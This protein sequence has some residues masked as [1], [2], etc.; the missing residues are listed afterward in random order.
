MLPKQIQAGET[1]SS[2]STEFIQTLYRVID[3]HFDKFSVSM[4]IY[5]PHILFHGQAQ[6]VLVLL[7]EKTSQSQQVCDRFRELGEQ[8]CNIIG[9][10][11][12]GYV[13]KNNDYSK[14]W[15]DEMPQFRDHSLFFDCRAG[16]GGDQW[17]APWLE[18]KMK[19]EL[20]PQMHQ[21]LEEWTDHHPMPQMHQSLEEW[22][23]HHPAPGTETSAAGSDARDR[24]APATVPG[25]LQARVYVS[26]EEMRE[27]ILPC[28][29]CLKLGKANP[30]GFKRDECMLSIFA[31]SKDTNTK[32][33]LLCFGCKEKVKVK[34]ILKRPLFLSYNWG[35]DL[36]TQKI[37]VPLC[38]R[39]FLATEMPYWLDVDGGM[40][41]GDEL[42]TEMREG[43]AGCDIVILMISDA[44]CNSGNCLREF[45]HTVNHRKHII[46]LLV[47]DC[48]PVRENGPSSGWTGEY[49]TGDE[50]WWKHAASICTSKDPDAPDKA[51]QWSYLSAFT[52]IDL[53]NESLNEDG[54]LQ[55]HSDAEKEI[56]LR[57]MSRF[58]RSSVQSGSS[59][60]AT[61]Q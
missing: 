17:N 51:I 35:K 30:G 41:F 52:P 26:K 1:E 23:D 29:N 7:D 14:W 3:D 56:I 8:G 55:D 61:S 16:P 31:V 32:G 2:N 48:G 39:I 46:P 10:L 9:V 44:F 34:D 49:T 19:R 24:P 43:V 21:F 53:R 54:S 18:D 27:S 4:E 5:S 6:L 11:M 25:P 37:A 57:V 22:T 42:I 45:V 60:N 58:F 15:P 38:K 12:P 50:D 33:T 40:G 28:P 59:D 47:P 13:V 20:M 36:S